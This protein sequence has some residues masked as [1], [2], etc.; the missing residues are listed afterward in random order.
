M[1][2]L[3]TKTK[4][5][6]GLLLPSWEV[7]AWQELMVQRIV[8]SDA[9]EISVIVSYSEK[10]NGRWH[11]ANN[12][13]GWLAHRLLKIDER[14]FRA[15]I[16][17]FNKCDLRSLLS[18]VPVLPVSPVRGHDNLK[19]DSEDV[20]KLAE[21]G[22]DVLISLDQKRPEK[23]ILKAA[24]HG[25]WMHD[26]KF[27]IGMKEVLQDEPQTASSLIALREGEPELELYRSSSC[28]YRYSIRE[29]CNRHH[30]RMAA[31]AP[32][33]L[34]HLS[35]NK[36]S[37]F[38]NMSHN[39]SRVEPRTAS[40]LALLKFWGRNLTYAIYRQ[41]FI[42]H[43]ILLY[44]FSDDIS[45]RFEEY[46]KLVPPK[47]RLWADPY[48]LFRDGK[49]YLF[50]EEM[51]FDKKRIGHI[52]LAVMDE[53][54]PCSEP[55]TVLEEPFHLSYPFVFE[56]KDE[57]YMIPETAGARAIRLY[58][59][60]RF[61]DQWQFQY[62]LI[63]NIEANDA[64]L[65]CDGNRWWM[66]VSVKEHEGYPNWDELFLF[67]SDSPVSQAWQPHPKNPVV[68][69]VTSARPA[70]KL[71]EQDGE[72]YRPAQNSAHR[73]GYGLKIHRIIKLTE[74]EYEEEEVHSFEPDWDERIKAVHSYNRAGKLS[75]I[76]A[77]LQRLRYF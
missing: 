6:V 67:Y 16:D 52:A 69:D 50:F 41:L 56:W 35:D 72:I 22:L 55:V 4:L 73:Y 70:G 42:E 45:Y 1:S 74:T 65:F 59:C 66:F 71:F 36:P 20:K 64:T 44:C 33:A 77:R 2:E 12:S 39:K 54:G 57:T 53:T 34:E 23:D 60:V 30:W 68:S 27:P 37:E 29:N 43:W 31:F 21:Y 26:S 61:P 3:A 76:D 40:T 18:S 25:V 51:I 13:D 14:L 58:K 15:S 62:N 7:P 32:R 24:R 5:R 10:Q 46:R 48:V 49:Y 11:L 38:E 17:A 28:T 9:A 63:N 75:V 47:D 19:F 8:Q